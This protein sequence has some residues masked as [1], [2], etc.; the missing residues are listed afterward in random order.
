[1][2]PLAVLLLILG[3]VAALIFAIL[4][5][6]DSRGAETPTRSVTRPAEPESEALSGPLS[7]PG[8]VVRTPAEVE[9]G[10][11]EISTDGGG[12][13]PNEVVGN[14]TAP[15]GAPVADAVVSLS[16]DRGPL[17]FAAMAAAMGKGRSTHVVRK[18][19]TDANGN[20]RFTRLQPG[21]NYMVTVEH[22]EYR[23]EETD[24]FEVPEEG[25]VRLDV[26]IR[27]GIRL[28]GYV[29]DHASQA[30]VAGAKI[31]IDDPVASQLPSTVN[32]PNR[33]TIESSADGRY[34]FTHL[35]PTTYYLQCEAEGYGTWVD[36][37]VVISDDSAYAEPRTIQLEPELIIAGRVVAPDRTAVE[38]AVIDAI[39]ITAGALSRGS[40]T[41][42][43]NGDFVIH[44]LRD[45]QYH[46]TARA[47][48][49]GDRRMVRVVAGDENLLIEMIEQGGVMGRV[50]DASSGRPL[51]SFLATVRMTNLNAT[52]VGRKVQEKS[53]RNSENG[54]FSLGGLNYGFYVVQV[55]ANGYAD[56]RSEPFTIEQGIVTPDVVIA[57]TRGGTIKGQLIDAYSKEPLSNVLVVT[58][59]STWI[60]SPF[61]KMF[62]DLTHR[63]TTDRRVRTD[64]NGRY[65]MKLLTPGDYQLRFSRNDF[66]EI[67]KKDV[68]LTEGRET[69]LG[70]MK[71]FHGAVISGTCWQ[72]DGSPAAGSTVQMYSPD[73]AGFGQRYETRTSTDGRYVLKNVQPGLY[74][75]SCA[76]SATS[77]AD[78]FLAIVDI[79]TSEVEIRVVDDG[80]YT[81]DLYLGD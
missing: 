60:D 15:G 38:G 69:D 37:R 32:S 42:A 16:K 44:G 54:A 58:K 33:I 36:N 23:R 13:Y 6:G 49:W 21:E 47:K 57:M 1:M 46:V 12:S 8:D 71:M 40:G 43:A 67:V 20:Y 19:K 26:R 56:T 81:Q 17:A 2:R 66:T 29:R 48:G 61:T 73:T 59:D 14:V 7:S 74:K 63:L 79:K 39:S 80:E 18:N 68:V 5:V 30:P 51:G 3:A 22:S 31:W 10:R 27:P 64:K 75:L 4:S 76:R 50:I 34:E 72:A 9:S 35:S 11:N 24:A 65:E 28:F 62:Q 77:A 25:S 78:P 52:Y 55:S 45:A 53:Y 41:S 70:V